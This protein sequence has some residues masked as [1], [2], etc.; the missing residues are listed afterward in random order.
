MKMRPITS[1]LR[2]AVFAL[3]T[4]LASA[5][6]AQ[7]PNG[8]IVLTGSFTITPLMTDIARRFESANPGVAIEIRPVQTGKGLAE[9]RAGNA[10]IAMVSRPLV[11]TERNL[12]NFALCRDGAAIIV[13]RTNPVKNLT[14]RQL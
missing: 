10:D 2:T 1:T 12:F 11:G 14:S 6:G 9:L 4:L 5:A 3:L 13:H 7:P 8:K